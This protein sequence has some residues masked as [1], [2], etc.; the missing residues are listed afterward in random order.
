M[1][2]TDEHSPPP[3]PPVPSSLAQA[4]EGVITRHDSASHLADYMHS[5]FGSAPGSVIELP[6]PPPQPPSLLQ[7]TSSSADE[8]SSDLVH[9]GGFQAVSASIPPAP[10][11][12]HP[13][14]EHH[15]PFGGD[16][17][18]GG[19]LINGGGSGSGFT[20]YM[21]PAPQPSSAEASSVA[22]TT[23]TPVTI[24]LDSEDTED[25]KHEQQHTGEERGVSSEVGS[26]SS[27]SVEAA[28]PKQ[29]EVSVVGSPT[30]FGIPQPQP[31]TPESDD[32]RVIERCD[33]LGSDQLSLPTG[34][35][36][37][38]A[39]HRP[40][41]KRFMHNAPDVPVP[42][43]SLPSHP[44]HHLG[45]SNLSPSAFGAIPGMFD[46]LRGE[47]PGDVFQQA[48]CNWQWVHLDGIK[49]PVVN[50]HDG[51]FAAV[52]IVQ[53]KFLSKFPPNIPLE[54][55]QRYTM[56]SQKMTV[57]ESWIFNTINAV[58]CKFDLGCQL[59]TVH[60]EIVRF[61]DVERF[62]WAVKA[63]N[64]RRILDGYENE[65]RNTSP[66]NFALLA[67]IQNLK[68]TIEDDLEDVKHTL[69]SL[70]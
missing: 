54:M 8:N 19:A 33:I 37:S 23:S 12:H 50:R 11:Y 67:T 24:H 25:E 34:V 38:P 52:H 28:D 20:Q 30:V 5:Y 21:P 46:G 56:V 48:M 69:S 31:A 60:D 53:L 35:G 66:F 10:M 36:D 29:V 13:H 7:T 47:E 49:I 9:A 58:M 39:D 26:N 62:Y 6:P 63:L 16:L 14:R 55:T 40:P 3:P 51:T 17:C 42:P 61:A 70:H 27:S 1:Q 65:L 43:G 4:D 45:N 64:L 32:E 15:L 2:Q 41:K 18:N 22:T 57:M 59:F 68:K 44:H